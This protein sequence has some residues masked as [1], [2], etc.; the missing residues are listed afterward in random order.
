MSYIFHRY[1]DLSATTGNPIIFLTMLSRILSSNLVSKQVNSYSSCV[2]PL[3]QKFR[4]FTRDW[5]T[6]LLY[7]SLYQK[8]L[9]SFSKILI[10][11]IH[12]SNMNFNNE[13]FAIISSS[14]PLLYSSILIFL[15]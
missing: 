11:F 12:F 5:K 14:T 3:Y 10:N 4:G 13:S 7:H 9:I 2:A 6:L 1:S 8:L 15:Y